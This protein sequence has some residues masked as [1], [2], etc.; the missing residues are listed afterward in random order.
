MKNQN[1]VWIEIETLNEKKE[2][3]HSLN[4]QRAKLMSK[5]LDRLCEDG[6][7]QSEV[8]WD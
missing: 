3:D 7:G 6:Q 5:M 8:W 2:I 4:H 1:R